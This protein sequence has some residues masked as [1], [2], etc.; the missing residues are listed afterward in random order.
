MIG[1]I[2][3]GKC[4]NCALQGQQIVHARPVQK[5]LSRPFLG[6]IRSRNVAI[7]AAE[8]TAEASTTPVPEE[9]DASESTKA[10]QEPEPEPIVSLSKA[11]FDD[12][13]NDDGSGPVD[14]RDITLCCCYKLGTEIRSWRYCKG[15]SRKVLC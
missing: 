10:A 1:A 7:R 4:R 9:A 2:V 14:R 15:G 13:K 6:R 5:K 3:T 8:Q 12:G 11:L